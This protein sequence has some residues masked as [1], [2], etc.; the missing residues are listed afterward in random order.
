M[1]YAP[2]VVAAWRQVM[3]VAAARVLVI[4]I[5][6]V[7]LLSACTDG[8][9]GPDAS[10]IIRMS[11]VSGNNQTGT[12]GTQLATALV[13]Q[14]VDGTNTPIP[15]LLVNF[16]VA[17]GGGSAYAGSSLTNSSGQAR[18]YWILGPTAGAQTLEVRVVNATS[19]VKTV[20]GSFTATANAAAAAKLIQVAGNLQDGY[21]AFA[22]ATSPTAQVTD[23]FGN[24]KGGISVTFAVASG[25]GSVSGTS[26]TNVS[27]TT[28]TTASDGTAK[29]TAWTLG[30]APGINS[31]TASS[32]G[33]AGS[34]ST[35]FANAL[36]SVKAISTGEFHTCELRADGAAYCTGRNDDGEFGNGTTTPWLSMARAADGRMFSA[37]AAGFN[38][39]CGLLSTG[40]AWCWGNSDNGQLGNGSNSQMLPAQVKGSLKFKSI[41]AGDFYTC[42]ITTSGSGYCWGYNYAGQ[43]GDNTTLDRSQPTAIT[44]SFTWAQLSV[45][46]ATT[47][48]VTTAGAG[49][50]WGDNTEGQMG[51]GTTTSASTPQA[52]S[53]NLVWRRISPG[54]HHTCGVTTTNVGYCWGENTYGQLGNGTTNS[55]TIPVAVSG[56]L[57]WQEI[58]GNHYMTCGLTTTGKAF[59][60]GNNNAGAVGDGTLTNRSVPTAVAT[61]TLFAS[62]GSGL[63]M[64]Q[65]AV[66][67][68]GGAPWCWGING[69][70][71]LGTGFTSDEVTT[72]YKVLNP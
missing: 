66:A 62:L 34:P 25:G 7:A 47:C 9:T 37:I 70:G 40:D 46:T 44:G 67:K 48:G 26:G 56:G 4:S 43:I 61:G 23:A 33:L 8:A 35:F 12:V 69:D 59:C 53:G 49:F 64:G 10:A 29:P 18:D 57:A 72:P 5:L 71:E 63:N 42:G 51:N 13:I 2:G 52:V 36:F 22:V 65:C 68:S 28:Q 3:R 17:T 31:L 27:S 19:G 1:R 24:P 15:N 21:G 20:Y 32:T 55:S 50:C 54:N 39:T 38:H 11:V 16:D 6:S 45:N 30:G 58:G 14:A 60:W 41:T